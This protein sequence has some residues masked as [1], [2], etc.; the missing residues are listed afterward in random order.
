MLLVPRILFHPLI[1]LEILEV[2]LTETVIIR[3]VCHLRIEELRHERS[4]LAAVVYL[5]PSYDAIFHHQILRQ[6]RR[7][8]GH[9]MS[10]VLL[11]HSRLAVAEDGEAEVLVS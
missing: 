10:I 6:W 1:V 8:L 9:M 4:C 7:Y 3:Y 2:S 5:R 11:A